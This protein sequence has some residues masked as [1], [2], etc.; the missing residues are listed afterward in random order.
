MPSPSGFAGL[1]GVC[2]N[3]ITPPVGIYARNWGAATH[4]VAEG[5]HRPLTLTCITF[6]QHSSDQPLVLLGADLGWWKNSEHEVILRHA[7]LSQLSLPE[8]NLMFCLSHTHAGPGICLDDANK[9]GGELIRPYFDRLIT[10][11]VD[12]ARRALQNA[13]QAIL[14]WQ[15]GACN[16]AVNRELPDPA[17]DRIL[18]GYYPG[19]P[20]DNTLLVG[21]IAR[22]NG[23]ILGT[24]VNYACHPTTLAWQNRLISPDYV[25]AMRE[26]VESATHA[27]CFFMQG[28]SG[29]LSPPQQFVG[30]TALADRYGRQIGYAVLSTLAS[31]ESPGARLAYKGVVESGASLGMWEPEPVQVSGDLKATLVSVAYPIKDFPLSAELEAEWSECTDNVL[32]ERLWR[33]LC[34]RKAIGDG[35]TAKVSLWIWQVG[36]S[37]LVG[38]PNEAYSGF[39][40][41]VREEF[42]TRAVVVMNLVN[43]SIGYLPPRPLY[44][45]NTY[46]VWQTPFAAGSLDLLMKTTSD[47]VGQL[48]A[49]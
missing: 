26:T 49:N 16:L 6:Q 24:L 48:L 7:I 5:I 22:E 33:K 43:G 45:L 40:Q 41:S 30:E 34:I 29:E 37:I 23:E 2:Q 10:A 39:Q 35:D 19:Q 14:T 13:G 1:I 3:D 8:Q 15:Y 31:M 47:T 32:K 20:A 18:T 25:G 38:Q 17:A 9:P 12:A 36:D 42:S 4:D 27:P 28:A 44:Q 46:P 11:S 21:R